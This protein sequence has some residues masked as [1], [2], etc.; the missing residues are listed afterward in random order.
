LTA[1]GPRVP[2]HGVVLLAA[3]SNLLQ[4]VLRY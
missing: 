2:P 4:P 3:H 1:V